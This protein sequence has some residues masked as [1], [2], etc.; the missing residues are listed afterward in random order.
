LIDEVEGMASSS[1][2]RSRFGSLIRAYTLVGYIPEHSYEFIEINRKLRRLHR[3]IVETVIR[4]ISDLGGQISEDSETDLLII[5]DEFTAS[6]ALARCRVTEAGFYRWNILFDS[7]LAPDITVGVR[8]AA[9]D[10]D[11]LDYYLFPS[12]DI[13]I[14]KLL[15]REHNALSIETYRFETL[16]YF[17]G[18]ARRAKIPGAA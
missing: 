17:F 14:P 18:M 8:M 2:Y 5:N 13:S 12:L 15:L 10:D 4:Q 7:A 9:G 1:V 6:I 3:E 11:I 16:D